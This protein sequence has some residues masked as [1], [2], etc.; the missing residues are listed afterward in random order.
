VSFLAAFAFFCAKDIAASE[1]FYAGTLGLKEAIRRPHAILW[2][3][4][5]TAFVG[6]TSGPGRVPREGAAVLALVVAS[7]AEVDAWHARI[8][9][10][11]W[12]TDGSPRRTASGNYMFFA[13][14]PD[15]YPVEILRSAD[16]I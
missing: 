5:D 13:T 3:V 14:D 11:G 7:D 6:V 1:R 10:D 4:T 2:R 9:G 12:A 15:G 8:T 16:P